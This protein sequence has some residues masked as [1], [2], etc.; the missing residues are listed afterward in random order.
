MSWDATLIDDRGHIELDVNYT[1]NCNGMAN[2][3]L[4]DTELHAGARRWW[5]KRGRDDIVARIDAGERFGSWWDCLD[6]M[7]G[8]EGRPFSTGSS[9][10]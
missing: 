2:A 6:G 8:E 1:H 4:S 10:A 5:S 7:D 3:V 9:L